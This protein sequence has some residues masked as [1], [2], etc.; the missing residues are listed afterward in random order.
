VGED[1]I[2]TLEAEDA[3]NGRKGDAPR[4]GEV[5]GTRWRYASAVEAARHLGSTSG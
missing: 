4:R 5:T 2:T 1:T 3:Q